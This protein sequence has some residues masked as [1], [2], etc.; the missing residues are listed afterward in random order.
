MNNQETFHY[1][2]LDQLRQRVAELKLDLEFTE[3]LAPL[4]QPVQVG[5]RTLPNRLVVLPM[6]CW[7]CCGHCQCPWR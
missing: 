4:L 7:C 3:D 2:T 5:S 6:G 1:H